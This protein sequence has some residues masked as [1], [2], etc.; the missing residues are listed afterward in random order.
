MFQARSLISTAGSLRWKSMPEN[1]RKKRV[2]ITGTDTGVGKTYLACR[3]A[4]FLVHQGFRVGVMKPVETGLQRGRISDAGRLIEASSSLLPPDVIS[5]YRYKSPAA[6]LVAA[7]LEK[8]KISIKQIKKCFSKILKESD[9]ILV[10]GAG[11][12][13]VP[14]REEYMMADLA[15][16]LGLEVVLVAENRLGTLNQ[17][18]LSVEVLRARNLPIRGVIL[19]NLRT[20]SGPAMKTNFKVLKQILGGAVRDYAW[21]KKEKDWETRFWEKL[22]E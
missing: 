5:P 17:T 8:K 11:G 20:P 18:L 3:W 15:S 21:G 2:L 9:W 7:S 1:R 22:S 16:E 10:E 19:N 12:L 4:R 13:M 14:I 6:P